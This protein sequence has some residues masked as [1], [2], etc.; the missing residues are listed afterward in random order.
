MSAS[1]CRLFF[2]AKTKLHEKR[3]WAGISGWRLLGAPVLAY[4]QFSSIAQ[5]QLAF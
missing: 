4:D 1:E 2:F 5:A 3:L